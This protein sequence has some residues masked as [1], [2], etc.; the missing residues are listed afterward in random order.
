L[1]RESSALRTSITEP[2]AY[3]GEQSEKAL[4]EGGGVPKYLPTRR[5]LATA[6]SANSCLMI[7]IQQQRRGA[8]RRTLQRGDDLSSVASLFRCYQK[9]SVVVIPPAIR[10]TRRTRRAA[11]HILRSSSVETF[12]L[13]CLMTRHT[14]TS[15][16]IVPYLYLG[17][18]FV[19][20]SVDRMTSI[21]LRYSGLS[22]ALRA[23]G[24]SWVIG[25]PLDL[26]K[27]P[28]NSST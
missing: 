26:P 7:T 9:I 1:F 17:C 24:L 25:L 14:S 6:R 11:T 3:R 22:V 5:P 16:I 23:P 2:L 21:H 18:S 8:Q 4:R 27:R 10:T 20:R 28:Q 15:L 12:P 19:K 13:V